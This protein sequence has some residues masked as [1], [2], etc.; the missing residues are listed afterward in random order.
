MIR[1]SESFKHERQQCIG[2]SSSCIST[3]QKIKYIIKL[4]LYLMVTVDLILLNSCI[5]SQ[6]QLEHLSTEKVEEN[7]SSNI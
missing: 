7:A 1:L 4:T 3:L 5:D 6:K 2:F